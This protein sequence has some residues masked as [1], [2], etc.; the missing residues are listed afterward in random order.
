MGNALR[1]L[2]RSELALL[3]V[4]AMSEQNQQLF[5]DSTDKTYLYI[6]YIDNVRLSS[7]DKSVNPHVVCRWYA[8]NVNDCSDPFHMD[9]T[10]AVKCAYCSFLVASFENMAVRDRPLT[11]TLSEPEGDHICVAF[12]DLKNFSEEESFKIEHV[13]LHNEAGAVAVAE[14]HTA[15]QR[16]W[17]RDQEVV[18]QSEVYFVSPREDSQSEYLFQHVVNT[19]ITE[20]SP[21]H[22]CVDSNREDE[23]RRRQMD[24][25][26]DAA[27]K[28]EEEDR[29]HQQ[30]EKDKRVKEDEKRR[31]EEENE[32]R[33]KQDEERTR[34]EEEEKEKGRRQRQ[35]DLEK[36]EKDKKRQEEEHRMRARQHEED[37]KEK[38]RERYREREREMERR[39]RDQLRA[40]SMERDRRMEDYNY[41][42]SGRRDDI[43]ERDRRRHGED[44][45]H[46]RF[47]RRDDILEREHRRYG[48]DCNYDRLRRRDD[49][50]ERDCR[51]YGEEEFNLRRRLDLDRD[52]DRYNEGRW[53]KAG[54]RD[55]YPDH[56][57]DSGSDRGHG[58]RSD[59]DWQRLRDREPYARDR[60]RQD[61]KRHWKEIG[62]REWRHMEEERARLRLDAKR[63]RQREEQHKQH[64]RKQAEANMTRLVD[65]VGLLGS[66]AACTPRSQ[67]FGDT[68][69]RRYS[70][71]DDG[72]SETNPF[73]GLVEEGSVLAVPEQTAGAAVLGARPGRAL[74]SARSSDVIGSGVQLPRRGGVGKA[75]APIQTRLEQLKAMSGVGGSARNHQHGKDQQRQ[76]VNE[77]QQALDEWGN[78]SLRPSGK[79]GVNVSPRMNSARNKS[80]RHFA[81]RTDA[82]V[83]VAPIVEGS[84]ATR[85]V[86]AAAL[87]DAVK[88]STGGGSQG[89]SVGGASVAAAE[90]CLLRLLVLQ[91]ELDGD[92]EPGRSALADATAGLV[93][94]MMQVLQV[95]RGVCEANREK[96]Q[97]F[98]K[99]RNLDL[100]RIDVGGAEYL[101][102]HL[103][104]LDRLQS[105]YSTLLPSACG[106]LGAEEKLGGG[107][108]QQEPFGELYELG[109]TS[110]VPLDPK[111]ARPF[112]PTLQ[113]GG[114]TPPAAKFRQSATPDHNSMWDAI[115]ANTISV[116]PR[117]A[118]VDEEA[119]GPLLGRGLHADHNAM[120]N[121]LGSTIVPSPHA[122]I[123]NGAP[124]SDINTPRRAPPPLSSRCESGQQVPLKAALQQLR[125]VAD[126]LAPAHRSRLRG[127]PRSIAGSARNGARS[128]SPERPSDE[129]LRGISGVGSRRAAVGPSDDKYLKILQSL[130]AK[131]AVGNSVP[132]ENHIQVAKGSSEPN[133]APVVGMRRSVG[134]PPKA[135]LFSRIDLNK[136]NSI[137]RREFTRAVR[138]GVVREGRRRQ[139]VAALEDSD[140]DD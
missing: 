29:R 9:G 36:H 42:R 58:D 94:R 130:Q 120:W 41:D 96:L 119:R 105:Q 24:E 13:E 99:E 118:V 19:E 57:K 49:I 39:E 138:E 100:D 18:P 98:C 23:A 6:M 16:R 34:H 83:Q 66:S 70:H 25:E 17:S 107:G 73:D 128:P 131:G 126:G 84:L 88:A 74:G 37:E 45:I 129:R 112:V 65:D 102:P 135:E 7:E 91:R 44:Y 26:A 4:A 38:E 111:S 89:S 77:V 117:I 137:S 52:R 15:S 127:T 86:L 82:S 104:A 48:E 101:K 35:D 114:S 122:Q 78:Q 8:D 11:L 67:T 64:R 30:E 63:E 20:A 87:T 92:E 68:I 47:G 72:D 31:K 40:G 124:S 140:S 123:A 22:S 28:R 134:A 136:D 133:F 55:W 132:D 81:Q 90:E 62:A 109:G 32:K 125:A 10:D 54:D 33:R 27:R 115:A 50:S 5:V 21:S 14:L 110:R 79:A 61:D 97:H 3:A 103:N 121:A 80:A 71:D 56:W 85:G 43:F 93:P 116:S 108:F 69:A 1:N 75:S 60:Q 106:R 12:L 2:A 53:D 76:S 51:R 59:I 113:S 139:V 95:A 46:D